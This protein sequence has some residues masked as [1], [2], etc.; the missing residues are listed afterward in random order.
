MVDELAEINAL[1]DGKATSFST[2]I[3]V[4]LNAGA[5]R[6]LEFSRGAN[7]VEDSGGQSIDRANITCDR[8]ILLIPHEPRDVRITVQNVAQPGIYRAT[9]FFGVKGEANSAKPV[10]VVLKA[11]GLPA[12]KVLQST[13]SLQATH[14]NFADFF[15]LW[16]VP[17]SS[18]E[19]EKQIIIENSGL[20]PATATQA[21]IVTRAP[22]P[23]GA[24]I[25][26]T[27]LASG[28]VMQNGQSAFTLSVKPEHLLPGRYEGTVRFQAPISSS[29]VSTAFTLDVRCGPVIP[30]LVIFLGIIFGRAIQ[31]YSA[32]AVQQRIS[33]LDR[34]AA[35]H[36]L[37]LGIRNASAQGMFVAQVEELIRRVSGPE[38][39]ET[40]TPLVVATEQI[41][42]SMLAFDRIEAILLNLPDA[43]QHR[44]QGLAAVSAGRGALLQGDQTVGKQCFDAAQKEATSA[45]FKPEQRAAMLGAHQDRERKGPT[46]QDSRLLA[47]IEFLAGVRVP[48]PKTARSWLRP[49][50]FVALLLLLTATGF[51]TLYLSSAAATL[52]VGGPFDFFP[53]FLW[54]LGSDVVQRTIQNLG[55]G[56][57]PYPAFGT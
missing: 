44:G 22:R 4:T 51:S 41:V 56:Q 29:I 39:I 25:T 14:S 21:L 53:L 19:I 17:P 12:W 45:V 46:N 40:L 8:G 7:L 37:A 55:T 52:G 3:T 26:V 16:A 50:F 27:P 49:I 20:G 33:L 31:A 18:K 5:Q 24:A 6:E 36:R 35:V 34:L 54:G 10:K 38:P 47:F 15:L 1:L 9:V 48:T 13:V 28:S 11:A 30:A 32:P 2:I 43:D 23:P 42:V 57:M